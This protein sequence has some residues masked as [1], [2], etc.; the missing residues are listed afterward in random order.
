MLDIRTGISI[1][2]NRWLGVRPGELI[3]L[4]TD[5]A[6]RREMEAFD[7]WARG[8]DAVL[9]TIVVSSADVQ[10]G[11][12]I[13]DMAPLLAS[14]DV[15]LGATEFSFIT[16][17]PVTEAVARGSFRCRCPAP[18]ARACSRMI[19]LIWIPRGRTGWPA[20]CSEY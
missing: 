5:E 6:H 12:V 9:K 7:T 11:T 10:R 2:M 3:L 16:T 20:V 15:I 1:I 4:V 14:A 17:R 8:Q 13:D 19:L 18:T